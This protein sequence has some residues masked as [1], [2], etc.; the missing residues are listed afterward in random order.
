MRELLVEL[1][2]YT[3]AHLQLS[4]VALTLAAA[5][6]VPLGIWASRRPRIAPS[7]LG[8]AGALQTIPSLALLAFMVPLLAMLGAWT[9]R[10]LGFE[11][12][13]I[14]RGPALLAL[15]LYGTL[16]ILQNTVAGLA[17]VD[18]AVREAATAM[19]MTDR[20]KLWRVELPLALPV[21]VAG[22]RTAAVWVVGTAT[23]ATPVGAASLGHFIFSGLQTRNYA[24]VSVGCFAAA[25]LAIALER[26]IRLLERGLAARRR[27]L[28]VAGIAA[29]AGLGLLAGVPLASDR[30]DGDEAP[31]VIGAKN[32][33]EQYILAEILA[34]WIAR[35]VAGTPTH[36]LASLGSTVLFDALRANEVD[37]YVDYTGTLWATVLARGGASPGREA[38]LA[39]IRRAL[40]TEYGIEVAAVLG[41]ENAY[42]LAMRGDRARAL[43]ITSV[44]ELA[45]E[46][47]RLE[48]GADYEF[49]ARAEW[50]ALADAY[51]LSF[52]ATRSMDPS[53]MYEALLRGQVDV[54]SAF[55][56]DGRIAALDL[57]LL[58]EPRG[59]I[60]PYDAIV[61]VGPRLA[62]ERPAIVRAL[63]GREGAIDAR[64]MQRLNGLVDQAGRSPRAVA[65]EW[66]DQR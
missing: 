23:L 5:V 36:V 66:L 13:A 29:L 40:A 41:F 62:R 17:G 18:P 34:G 28:V 39:E 43:G 12:A 11:I 46:A 3:A 53:L 26:T 6:S 33:T 45:R 21:M 51:R 58:R 19:G 65:R 24:A 10:V 56:S 63:H 2:A 1:P 49:L 22:L 31:V 20:Q 57:A 38:M 61:L 50:R 44:A 64:T 32:F 30:G 14:G 52:R 55:S 35:D 8:T 54:I 15:S 59:V 60:P 9:S 47:P 48:L 27:G 16:P 42:V 4:L 37:V 25:V 7:V